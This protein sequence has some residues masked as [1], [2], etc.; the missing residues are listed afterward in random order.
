VEELSNFT[1]TARKQRLVVC[2][3]QK[4]VSLAA[5]SV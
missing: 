4:W 5:I 1:Y 3:V 2:S